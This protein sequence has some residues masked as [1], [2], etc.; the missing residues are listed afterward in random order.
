MAARRGR[1]ARSRSTSRRR[2]SA[3]ISASGIT[4]AAHEYFHTWNVKRIRPVALGPFDYTAAQHQPSL[5]VAEG[6]TQYYGDMSLTRSGVAPRSRL[7]ATLG[8]I[9]TL[10][11]TSPA[12]KERSPRQASFDEIGQTCVFLA[13]AASSYIT[14]QNV[15]VDGGLVRAVR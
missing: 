4:T 7:Y 2:R 14:G 12:R 1:S 13:S 8:R 15:L 6:W 10:T 9:L 11:S 3:V 5:W